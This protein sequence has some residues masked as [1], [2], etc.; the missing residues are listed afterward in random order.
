MLRKKRKNVAIF[1]G[2]S[3]L[4]LASCKTENAARTNTSEATLIPSQEAITSLEPLEENSALEWTKDLESIK[5][6]LMTTRGVTEHLSAKKIETQMDE[7]I[8]DAKEHKIDMTTAYYRVKNVISELHCAHMYIEKNEDAEDSINTKCLGIGFEWFGN[9]LRIVYCLENTKEYL[10]WKVNKIAGRSIEEAVDLFASINSYET[11]TGKK[12]FLTQILRESELQY[13]GMLNSTGDGV[14]LTV[15][16]DD[17]KEQKILVEMVTDT[18]E[19]KYY[20][21][22]YAEN[23]SIFEQNLFKQQN[24]SYVGDEQ[25]HTMFFL[26]LSCYD[27]KEYSFMNCFTDMMNEIKS[28]LKYKNLVIDVSH[29]GGG[30]RILM[31]DAIQ[32]YREDLK[33]IN[34]SIIIGKDTHSAAFQLIADY[35]ANFE[36]VKLYGE[37]TGQAIHHYTETRQV[38]LSNMNLTLVVPTTCGDEKILFDRY[39]DSS[40]GILPD[41]EVYRTYEDS[42]NGVDTIYER[43]LQ[44]N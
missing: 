29:N 38:A 16:N 15:Q 14:E 26:Y 31:L 40:R 23:L 33:D 1:V 27:M 28:N 4:M 21:R 17:G 2:I 35:L 42:I 5:T 36:H 34:I 41:V 18:S 32:K 24:Y 13:L 8:R 3:M 39:K 19:I 11:L 37:E 7:I 10:G 6:T 20:Y 44:D 25:N 22:N 43:I 30:N 9:D 12:R